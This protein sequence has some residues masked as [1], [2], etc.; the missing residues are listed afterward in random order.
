LHL[1]AFPVFLLVLTVP[2]LTW[3]GG[4]AKGPKA[5]RPGLYL[6]LVLT[7][8]QAAVFQWQFYRDGP[9]RGDAFDAGFPEAFAA[10]TALQSRP[11]YLIGGPGKYTYVHA[12]WYGTL[13]GMDAS[14]FVRL[15][16]GARPPAQ[17]LVID[18]MFG[19]PCARCQLI[20]MRPPYIV[21]RVL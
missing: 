3:L 8:L 17:S 18:D 6:L 10:A 20:L 7:L 4:S 14:A 15:S 9:K 1:S 19:E 21:Y 2:A 5:A 12:Y 11:I 16:V 13:G